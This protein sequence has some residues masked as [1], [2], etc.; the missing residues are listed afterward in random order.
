MKKI[1]IL[2]T[3]GTIS[4]A[5]EGGKTSGYHDGEFLVQ[6]L[7]ES[8]KGIGTLAELD[9]EQ[10]LNISSDD[11]TYKNWTLLAQRI[12]MLAQKEDIDGF[13]ITHGTNTMEET[14]YFL[15]LTVKTEKPVVLT[16]SMRPATANSADGPQNL[17][18]AVAL[19]ASEEARGKGVLVVFS[20]GIY[21]A[22][23]VQKVNCFRPT[24]YD[25]KDFGCIGYMQDARPYFVQ[26]P[27][28]PHTVNSEFSVSGDGTYP[29]VEIAYFYAD[30]DVQI[31]KYQA[32]HADGLI[33]AGAGS[34]LASRPWKQAI[35]EITERIPVVRT[36]RIGNG[37]VGRE[38]IDDE[39][40]TIAGNLLTPVKARIL[41]SLAL[42]QT[43]ETEKLQTIFD[44]Y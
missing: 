30:A 24:A 26:C 15:N 17:Y 28:R 18:E 14:A 25:G 27:A 7:L 1:Y 41:L 2:A 40:H 9:G 34:G 31:L 4:A 8:V 19:A 3:G 32:E 5:G 44:Q 21:S 13:V 11:V 22:D 20:D 16:G 10:I 12:N 23:K 36:T 35:R 43:H 29:K 39:L 42:M 6:D 33:L 37:L 38:F